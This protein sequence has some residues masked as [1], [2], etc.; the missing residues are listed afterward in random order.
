MPKTKQNSNDLL[1]VAR[2]SLAAYASLVYPEYQLYK[3]HQ[4]LIDKLEA[5]EAGKIKRLMI[6]MPPRM[7]KSLTTTEIFPAWYLGRNP[8]KSVITASYSQEFVEG[9]GRKVRNH[10]ADPRTSSAFP[11]L[12]LA[13][14]SS[15]AQRFDTTAGGSYFAEPF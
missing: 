2:I 1:A 11:S 15:S 3:H 9:F 8:R 14:D 7:G 5:V 6:S 12:Q 4:M 10:V 13:K